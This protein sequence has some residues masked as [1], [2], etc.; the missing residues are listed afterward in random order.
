MNVEFMVDPQDL[1]N[2]VRELA[3]MIYT[4]DRSIQIILFPLLEV[5]HDHLGISCDINDDDDVDPNIYVACHNDCANWPIME[6]KTQWCPC[7]CHA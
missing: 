6:S 3:K 1:T 7:E 2:Q 4:S 5:L